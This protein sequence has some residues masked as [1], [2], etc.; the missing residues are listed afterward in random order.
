MASGLL[1]NIAIFVWLARS[2]PVA[3]IKSL[4]AYSLVYLDPAASM[5]DCLPLNPPPLEVPIC[6]ELGE[7][8]R[9]ALTGCEVSAK[10][11]MSAGA[12]VNVTP[13]VETTAFVRPSI[14]F[15]VQLSEPTIPQY[16]HYD[17]VQSRTAV[18]R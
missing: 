16:F 17:E 18:V 1:A 9:F 5:R 4:A 2:K 11:W 13:G 6:S 3:Y 10:P 8:P 12:Y 7:P 14:L 15:V